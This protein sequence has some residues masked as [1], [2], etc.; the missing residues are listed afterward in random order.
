MDL[1]EGFALSLAVIAGL[2]VSFGL[3]V[4]LAAWGL[5]RGDKWRY[6]N[7]PGEWYRSGEVADAFDGA[8]EPAERDESAA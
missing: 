5:R 6:G 8:E 7:D 3:F 1:L 2:G 4:V